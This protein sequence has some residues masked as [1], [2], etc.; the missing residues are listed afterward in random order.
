[1]SQPFGHCIKQRTFIAA[2]PEKVFDTI[3]SAEEWNSFFTTGLE[4]D[5][6]PGGKIVFRWKDWGPD[7]YNG[8]C[9]GEIIKFERPSIFSFDWGAK[10][11]TTV[12]FSLT[13]EFGGTVVTIT[14]D[15]YSDSDR[16]REMILE[17]ASGWGEALTLLKFYLEHGIIY[18]PPKLTG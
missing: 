13:E 17:C 8:E 2:S 10:N 14:E 4:L 18:T 16:D 7:F 6:Q 12:T 5:P 1:M 9:P 15:G 3:S 11:R